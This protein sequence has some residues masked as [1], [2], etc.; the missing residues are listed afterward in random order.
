MIVIVAGAKGRENN[1]L[2]LVRMSVLIGQRDPIWCV[3]SVQKSMAWT[4]I[5]GGWAVLIPLI[6]MTCILHEQVFGSS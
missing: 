1:Q 5:C 2:Q 4:N 3:L 6:Q